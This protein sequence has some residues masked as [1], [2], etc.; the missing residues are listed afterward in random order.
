MCS[1]HSNVKALGVNVHN[2][3]AGVIALD[4]SS[5]ASLSAV[6]SNIAAVSAHVHSNVKAVGVSAHNNI[7]DVSAL[8]HSSIASLLKS[9]VICI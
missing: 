1:V 4:H 5:T 7:A 9:T 8:D 3:I 2:N 6:H